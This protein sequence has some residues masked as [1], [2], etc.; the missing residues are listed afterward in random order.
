MVALMGS[1]AYSDASSE[2]LKNAQLGAHAPKTQDW[3]AIEAAAR[4]EG[5]VVIYSVSSR[6]FKLQEKFKAKYG[7]EIVGYDIASDMQ[8]EKFRREHK[9]G[10]HQVDVLFNNETPIIINEFLPRDLVWN[11]VPSTVAGQLEDSEKEPLLV[12]RWSSRIIFYNATKHN[13][14]APID[15]L[16][17][18]T[19]KE[20]GGRVLMPNPLESSVQANVIQTILQHPDEMAAAY[21]AEFGDDIKYSEKLLKA[22]KK[23]PLIDKP[24]AAKEWLAR[25]LANDPVFLSSTTKIFTNAGD[26][27]QDNP[28][29]GISTFSKMRKNKEGEFN[30]QP[31]LNVRPV[32]GVSYPTVLVVADQAPHPNAAKLLI[33]Y[34]MEDGFSPWNVPGDY[35]GRADVAKEQVA[36]FDLPPFEDVKMW[37]IDQ[38]YVYDT[39]YSYLS[40]YLG[41]K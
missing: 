31:A 37:P 18:L 9:A 12:Q 23:N 27:K 38:T 41:L 5:K 19:R 29:L 3:K 7:I 14:G 35:A 21:K 4:K 36:K 40:L 33:R 2:W 22:V 1:A 10:V 13:K 15:N 26:V 11:F 39:K 16:W 28:P 6:I 25:V 30:A 17:D 24:D 32:L 34:M 20:W 8:L